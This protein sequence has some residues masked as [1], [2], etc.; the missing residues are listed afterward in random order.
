MGK[1]ISTGLTV[2]FPGLGGA[3]DIIDVRGP[4]GSRK[5]ID[6]SHMGTTDALEFTPATL[7]DWG[8]VTF[9][10]YFDP[11]IKTI[12][13]EKDEPSAP[14]GKLIITFADSA[15]NTWTFDAFCVGWSP[16]EPFEDRATAD[17]T[18][19]VTGDVT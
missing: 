13:G 1:H 4:E 5:S 9:N 2:S 14:L 18:F 15:A 11:T 12:L 10:V 3:L 7:V 17:L 6:W 16:T 8:E 19:K